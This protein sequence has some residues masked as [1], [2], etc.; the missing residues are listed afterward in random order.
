VVVGVLLS[1]GLR[2]AERGARQHMHLQAWQLRQ[3]VARTRIDPL[4]SS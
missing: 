3:L 4:S 1:R 2:V